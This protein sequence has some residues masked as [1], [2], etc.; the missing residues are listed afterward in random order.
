MY[1]LHMVQGQ[2]A[3]LSIYWSLLWQQA[4]IP[5]HSLKQSKTSSDISQ[6]PPHTNE[7]SWFWMLVASAVR[8]LDG[9]MT[10]MTHVQTSC[11]GFSPLPGGHLDWVTW[12]MIQFQ[13]PLCRDLIQSL[14]VP[15]VA[16]SFLPMSHLCLLN[17]GVYFTIHESFFTLY[18]VE[19]FCWAYKWMK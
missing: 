8:T 17:S 12:Y 1:R 18:S 13:L 11:R 15:D 4:G 16:I 5:F 2:S 14:G 6:N 3:G 7:S 19:S 9:E 10:S